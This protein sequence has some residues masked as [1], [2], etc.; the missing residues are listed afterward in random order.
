MIPYLTTIAQNFCIQLM[1]MQAAIATRPEGEQFPTPQEVTAQLRLMS[2][3]EKANKQI[4]LLKKEAAEPAEIPAAV[5]TPPAPAL[6]EN[7][8]PLP[9]GKPTITWDDYVHYEHLITH[10][11]DFTDTTTINFH[12]VEV[13]RWW[14]IFNLLMFATGTKRYLGYEDC[15]RPSSDTRTIQIMVD[16]YLQ[17]KA[18]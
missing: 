6:A 15:T 14:L 7:T 12:G 2:A 16:D 11:I 8:N 1:N 4:A 3:I 9:E 5:A 17:K 10:N 18:A 13:E